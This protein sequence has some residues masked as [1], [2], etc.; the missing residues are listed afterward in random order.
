M[1][2]VLLRHVQD[3]CIAQ[4]ADIC[5]DCDAAEG[6]TL[7]VIGAYGIGKERAFLG[8]ARALGWKIWCEPEKVATMRM[9]QLGGDSMGLLTEVR[10]A[11]ASGPAAVGRCTA[12]PLPL[13]IAL[14]NT[15]SVCQTQDA[16]SPAAADGCCR[17]ALGREATPQ[18]PLLARLAADPELGRGAPWSIS[19]CHTPLPTQRAVCHQQKPRT[20]PCTCLPALCR[21]LPRARCIVRW[22]VQQWTLNRADEVLGVLA[23]QGHGAYPRDVHGA[24]AAAGAAGE[25]AGAGRRPRHRRIQTYGCAAPSRHPRQQARLSLGQ[26]V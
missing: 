11:A 15:C 19:S 24:G 9:L 1:A 10:G 5:R 13:C 23:G 4:M 12:A 16:A 17:F 8:T 18:G 6:G 25:A 14:G 20:G 22:K 7:F 21:A 26:G 2:T 3:V